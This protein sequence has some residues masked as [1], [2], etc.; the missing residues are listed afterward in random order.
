MFKT[1]LLKLFFSVIVLISD[2]VA[3]QCENSDVSKQLISLKMVVKPSSIG[4]KWGMKHSLKSR[5]LFQKIPSFY[6]SPLKIT[7]YHFFL[8][9]IDEALKEIEMPLF[10]RTWRNMFQNHVWFT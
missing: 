8:E 7:D 1:A 10:Y 5:T 3:G 6:Q 9:K 2:P 4:T